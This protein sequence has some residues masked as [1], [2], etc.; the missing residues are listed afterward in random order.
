MFLS[1]LRRIRRTITFRLILWYS[2]FFIL[3][4]SFLFILAYV[5]LASSVREKNRAETHQKISEYAAQYRSGGLEALK[6]EVGLEE[7][8]DKA[9][10]FFVRV[11]GPQNTNLFLNS[12]ER[13]KD[14]DLAQLDSNTAGGSTHTVNIQTRDGA[15]AVEIEST[16]LPN[17]NILQVG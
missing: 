13:W 9:D 17:G 2:T 14:I 4:T 3:S 8:S 12:P 6:N 11:A 7:R 16:P 1:R 5:L 15:K 10:A